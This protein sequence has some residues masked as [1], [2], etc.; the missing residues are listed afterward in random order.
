VACKKARGQT[1]RRGGGTRPVTSGQPARAEPANY[2]APFRNND[3]TRYWPAGTG[4]YLGSG[5]RG[6]RAGR[7]Q[8]R[9]PL[10]RP[11]WKQAK[12]RP[13]LAATYPEEST[14]YLR[15]LYDA[16]TSEMLGSRMWPAMKNR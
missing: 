2:C 11:A 5:L 14:P 4:H 8:N 3:I 7:E 12:K 16:L 10:V 1:V 9:D 6:R 15:P 13:S